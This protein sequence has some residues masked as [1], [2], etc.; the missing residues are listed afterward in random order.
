M[1]DLNGWDT[2]TNAWSV[3]RLVL[4]IKNRPSVCAL[5]EVITFSEFAVCPD[6]FGSCVQR[7]ESLAFRRSRF[8]GAL[9][10]VLPWIDRMMR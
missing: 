8:L 6:A 5:A 9:R 4:G 1:F 7:L 2:D 10:Q 3:L